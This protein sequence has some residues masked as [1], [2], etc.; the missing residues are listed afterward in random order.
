[1]EKSQLVPFVKE[2]LDILF[3]GLDPANGSDDHGHYFSVKQAFWNQLLSAGLITEKVSKL[4][5]DDEIFGNNEKNFNKWSYGITDLVPN[6][7]ESNS[8]NGLCRSLIRG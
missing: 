8:K 3:V 6:I 2:G 1:M 4:S 7:V 5:A